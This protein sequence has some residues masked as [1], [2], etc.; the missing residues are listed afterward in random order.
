[1]KKPEKTQVIPQTPQPEAQKKREPQ[2]FVVY[3]TELKKTLQKVS[4]GMA[5]KSIIPV[6]DFYLASLE[7]GVLTI[8]ATDLE[9]TVSSSIV[10]SNQAG[11]GKFLLPQDILKLV[12]KLDEQPIMVEVVYTYETFTENVRKG[13]SFVKETR[14]KEIQTITV[15]TD[16][17]VFEYRGYDVEEYP[18][19]E[20]GEFSDYVILETSELLSYLK[21]ATPLLRNVKNGISTNLYNIFFSNESDKLEIFT[22]DAY[23]WVVDCVDT[24]VTGDDFAVDGIMS[25]R[26]P[27]LLKDHTTEIQTSDE[28]VK[29]ISDIEVVVKKSETKRPNYKGI[30]IPDPAFVFTVRTKDF[31]KTLD[32]ASLADASPVTLNLRGGVAEVTTENIDSGRKTRNLVNIESGREEEE[33]KVAFNLAFLQ[34]FFNNMPDD[35]RCELCE[36]RT[37]DSYFLRCRNGGFEKLLLSERLT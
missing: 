29:F 16:S 37:N 36:Q 5:K 33:F 21:D 25:E 22:T 7:D 27:K 18:N 6:L 2:K 32:L 11:E 34:T 9:V 19:S 23:R 17:G 12:T 28:Y 1:M 3:S 15:L 26:L 4:V 8:S 31:L 13:E 35:T 14:I 24:R 20:F 30:L 10:L